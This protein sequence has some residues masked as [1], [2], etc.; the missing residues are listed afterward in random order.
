[1]FAYSWLVLLAKDFLKIFC[2][3]EQD[4]EKTDC[5]DFPEKVFLNFNPPAKGQ[6]VHFALWSSL[7][8]HTEEIDTRFFLYSS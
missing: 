6:H 7:V 3:E 2:A 1:M 5:L 4:E 8:R